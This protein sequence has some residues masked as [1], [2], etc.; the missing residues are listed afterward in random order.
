MG[1][2]KLPNEELVHLRRC[3]YSPRSPE[4]DEALQRYNAR[5]AAEQRIKLLTMNEENL[6]AEGKSISQRLSDV[7]EQLLE[8][9]AAFQA[10]PAEESTPSPTEAPEIATATPYEPSGEHQVFHQSGEDLDD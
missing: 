6:S 2:A 7:Q 5:Q 10:I 3:G 8:A 4:W 9:R 1:K